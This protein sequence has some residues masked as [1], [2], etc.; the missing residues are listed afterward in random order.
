MRRD[1]TGIAYILWALG[2]RWSERQKYRRLSDRLPS[3]TGKVENPW[4]APFGSIMRDFNFLLEPWIKL[5]DLASTRAQVLWELVT[6]P[7]NRRPPPGLHGCYGRPWSPLNRLGRWSRCLWP[8]NSPTSLLGIYWIA[9]E[10]LGRNGDCSLQSCM[11][12]A[13]SCF[14]WVPRLL[15]GSDPWS[16]VA[17]LDG[18]DQ[19]II[20]HLLHSFFSTPVGPYS[21][22][23]RLFAFLGELPAEGLPTV[24]EITWE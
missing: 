4:S 5:A 23:R 15:G 12:D 16:G 19:D 7:S 20:V 2:G 13:A 21:T 6:S 18:V 24:A 8:S 14:S 3:N 11:P 10:S 17:L 9:S 1:E 22:D